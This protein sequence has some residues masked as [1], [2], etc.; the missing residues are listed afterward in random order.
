MRLELLGTFRARQHGQD[1]NVGPPKQLAVLGFLAGRVNESVSIEEILDAV[2]GTDLPRTAANAVHT[3]VAGLRCALDLPR[4]GGTGPCVLASVGGAY[5]LRM[6]PEHV[7]TRSFERRYAEARRL[8]ANGESR[9][10]LELLESALDLWRGDAYENVPG[11]FAAAER[12]RLQ[13]LRVA[14]VEDWA[15]GMVATG[16]FSEA[17]APLTE[18]VAKDPLHE[19]LR[20]LLIVALQGCGQRAHALA[21]YRETREVLREELGIEPTVGLQAMHQQ[22]LLDSPGLNGHHTYTGGGLPAQ[23]ATALLGS[24]PRPA[25]LPPLDRGFFGRARELTRLRRLVSELGAGERGANRH[26]VAVVEGAPGVG[27]S[28]LALRLAHELAGSFPDGQLFVDLCGSSLRSAPLSVAQVQGFV[29]RSLGL[30][31]ASLPSEPEAR[32]ALYRSVLG[33]RRLL[34]FLDDAPRTA[35]LDPLLPDGPSCVLVTSRWRL[36]AAAHDSPRSTTA[37]MHRVTLQPLMPEE[38]V[39]L[40]SCLA[41]AERLA[42]EYVGAVRLAEFCGHLPLPLRIAAEALARDPELSVA[43]LADAVESG[44]LDQL[45]VVEDAAASLLICFRKSYLA[46]PDDTARMFRLLG[47]YDDKDITVSAAAVLAG[48]SPEW[49][50]AQLRTLAAGHLLEETKEGGYRISDLLHHF[51][52]KCAEQEPMRNRTAAL[53]RLFG[54]SATVR[55]RGD[56]PTYPSRDPVVCRIPSPR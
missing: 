53:S 48:T 55:G 31:Q 11:P 35:V 37:N 19:K 4:G 25:Q 39:R 33:S 45:A 20:G 5:S 29:L 56:D 13:E 21:V 7:D 22:I 8:S 46:L 38:S 15:S 28:A 32:T 49:A 17:V 6:N 51:A 42:A 47:L 9:L 16:R 34:L 3:Y 24:A 44:R 36:S 2:W 30:P 14:A 23:E 40:L 18:M 1:L 12:S 54:R 50:D 52:A 27:K 43:Q 26:L 10:A 41:G